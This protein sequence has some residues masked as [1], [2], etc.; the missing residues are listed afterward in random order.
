MERF[1][2]ESTFNFHCAHLHCFLFRPYDINGERPLYTQR[3][4]YLTFIFTAEYSRRN[5]AK[6]EVIWHTRAMIISYENW[7]RRLNLVQIKENESTKTTTF[8]LYQL[9]FLLR[10]TMHKRDK[11]V[12][13]CLSVYP[14]VTFVC[15]IET[16]ADTIKLFIGLLAPS[17]QFLEPVVTQFQGTPVCRC[18]KWWLGG[19]YSLTV[20]A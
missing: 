11:A 3:S 4:P 6:Q 20:I 19:K 8:G 5:L 18:I 1:I 15:S 14:S 16:T 2:T 9:R 13:R 17:F 7:V 12:G 10:D